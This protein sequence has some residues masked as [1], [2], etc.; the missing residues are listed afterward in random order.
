MI[1][2]GIFFKNFKK[3][4][5]LS[6]LKKK[7]NS[8]LK[9]N[10][11]IIQSLSSNYRDSFDKKKIGRFKKFLNYR[12]IG[13]GG[14][15]LGT[16]AI[17]DFLNY[18]IKKNFS[19]LDNLQ[20]NLK[21]NEK[22]KYLNLIVSKSGNTIE[23]IANSNIYIKKKDQN[24]FITENKKN[25]LHD[26]AQNL[27]ADI[28]HHNNFIGGRYSVLSEVGMLPAELMGLN[29]SKFRQLNNLVNNK[30]Y[31]NALL[32]NVSSTLYFL[33]KKKYNSIILNYDNRS[34]NLFSWYQQL[35]AE[36]LGKNNRGLLPIISNMPK[37]NHSVMQLYLD[38]FKNN[39][40]T[41]FYTHDKN[42]PKIINKTI[43]SSKNYIKNKN[44]SN[45]TYAQKIA[46]EIVFRKK[47]IPFRSIEIKKRD[48]KTLGELFTFFILE[49]ILLGKALKLNPYDQPAVELI[50]KETKKILV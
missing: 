12:I 37:D 35:V 49:T 2:S 8:I 36:S 28:I 7:L 3:K 1:T 32:S 48:E 47:N 21:N 22:K 29:S 10:N 34:N 13:M 20:P 31:L 46:T 4:K 40:Y 19:F 23:T 30:K 25:Y 16:Q 38:G 44:L 42:S 15:S 33:K 6:T 18:K 39:F 17:Y 41:F 50:K 45:I 9:E 5:E 24:I 43:L 11:N 14:S 26:L 27:K